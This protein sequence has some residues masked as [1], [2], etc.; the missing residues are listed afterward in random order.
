MIDKQRSEVMTLRAKCICFHNVW[1]AITLI[2]ISFCAISSICLFI[3]FAERVS[4]N[5]L[6]RPVPYRNNLQERLVSSR[7]SRSRRTGKSSSE[8][9]IQRAKLQPK[10]RSHKSDKL[11]FITVK[12][13][14]AELN[15]SLCLLLHT[16]LILRSH[17]DPDCNSA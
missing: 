3:H 9:L 2:F 1:L 11:S 12:L 4:C 6:K 8:V 5:T 7:S 16:A 10:L 13:S 15:S 17:F 14:R